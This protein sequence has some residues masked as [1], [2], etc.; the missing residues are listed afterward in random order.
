MNSTFLSPAGITP[1]V[2]DSPVVGGASVAEQPTE[3]S[4]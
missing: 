2:G 1:V 4:E 3:A